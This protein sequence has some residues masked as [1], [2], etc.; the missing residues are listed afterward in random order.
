MPLF[1]IHCSSI[2]Q[3]MTEP[4]SKNAEFGLSQTAK[5]HCENWLKERL[6][7]RRK[8]FDSKYTTKGNE[9]E[10][11]AINYLRVTLGWGLVFKNQERRENEW[12]TGECDLRLNDR[13]V[14][15]KSSWD[16]WTFPLFETECPEK[17]YVWQVT[18][19]MPLY[20]S[21]NASVVFVLMDTP[22]EI[23]RKEARFKLGEYYTEQDYER[24]AAQYKYEHLP[25]ELRVKQFDVEY[26]KERVQAIYEKV[27]NCR[28]YI[29]T[30][31]EKL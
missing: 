4:K 24:F 23:I 9:V 28:K 8:A 21:E 30:L 10:T 13:I 27:E 31:I 3:I 19:Y 6:Y 29:K 26:S 2:G 20:D 15:V 16:C 18:G 5:T 17:D 1:K 14:D 12:I 22:D 25:K 11:A 7:E